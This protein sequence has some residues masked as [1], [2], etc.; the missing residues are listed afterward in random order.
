MAI[1]LR[2]LSE[3]DRVKMHSTTAA[4]MRGHCFGEVVSVGRKWARVR[5]DAT[6]QIVL[7]A[8]GD[9]GEILS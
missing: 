1:F 9:I 4:W 2:D 6:S 5:L 7:C 3:K 8:P